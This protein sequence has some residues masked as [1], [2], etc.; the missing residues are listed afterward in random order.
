MIIL[1]KIFIEYFFKKRNR[2]L[3]IAWWPRALFSILHIG[4]LA[5]WKGKRQIKQMINNRYKGNGKFIKFM[6]EIAHLAARRDTRGSPL[7]ITPLPSRKP[8]S[9]PDPS[10]LYPDPDPNPP[11]FSSFLD[12]PSRPPSVDVF[13]FLLYLDRGPS[14]NRS[15]TFLPKRATFQE[16]LLN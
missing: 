5:Q 8:R 4:H 16:K 1:F 12:P 9:L 11:P 6:K 14:L 10:P 13:S 15:L 3:H 2:N 7:L